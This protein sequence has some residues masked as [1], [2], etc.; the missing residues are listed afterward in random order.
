[1]CNLSLSTPHPPQ[2]CCQKPPE[3]GASGNKTEADIS[4]FKTKGTLMKLPE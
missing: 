4:E 3:P 2:H 1:M